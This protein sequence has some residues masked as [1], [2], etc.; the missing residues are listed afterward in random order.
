MPLSS[1]HSSG[2]WWSSPLLFHFEPHFFRSLSRRKQKSGC[3]VNV[4]LLPNLERVTDTPF[5]FG[6]DTGGGVMCLL[7]RGR[8][9]TQ[10][11]KVVF[12]SPRKRRDDS[13]I[14]YLINAASSIPGLGRRQGTSS[15][16]CTSRFPPS[17]GWHRHF[18]R[19]SGRR[20]H[21]RWR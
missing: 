17:F 13:Y 5:A 10:K 12:A 15:L 16:N 20:R 6:V 14:F 11:S 1:V 7:Q 9:R 18:H 3:F 2:Y 21:R 19:H 8:V 4:F